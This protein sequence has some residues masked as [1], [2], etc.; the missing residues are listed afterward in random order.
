MAII[1]CLPYYPKTTFLPNGKLQAQI[2]SAPLACSLLSSIQEAS[3]KE[4]E[5][6]QPVFLDCCVQVAV[7]GDSPAS[8]AA[9]CFTF[10]RGKSGDRVA[11]GPPECHHQFLQLFQESDD[12]TGAA[13]VRRTTRV[14]LQLPTVEFLLD[15]NQCPCQSST[16]VLIHTFFSVQLH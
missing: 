16:K 5:L 8:A 4:L 1:N 2:T 14:V 12:C 11:P 13:Q 6:L 3:V 10:Q 9:G 7:V 15:D